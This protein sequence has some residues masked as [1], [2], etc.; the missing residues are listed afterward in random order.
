MSL[1]KMTPEFWADVKP[2]DVVQM[3]DEQALEDS[4]RR[5]DGLNPIDYVVGEI[6]E[7][8]EMNGLA[9]WT[10]FR[11]DD[12]GEQTLWLLLKIVDDAM[13]VRAY[14]TPDEDYTPTQRMDLINQGVT[15]LFDTTDPSIPVCDAMF[16]PRVAYTEYSEDGSSSEIVYARKNSTLTAEMEIDPP[17]E[18]V[19]QPVMTLVTEYLA[20]EE[21]QNPELLILEVGDDEQG[22][23]VYLYLGATLGENDFDVMKR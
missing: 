12:S 21:C 10:M 8:P 6:R 2:G 23:M 7:M 16:A 9:T 11:L 3:K 20:E 22:G 17:P 15:F 14:Y 4:L 5:G 19:P 13:D 18:G 1:N